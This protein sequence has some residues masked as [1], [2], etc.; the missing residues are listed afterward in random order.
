MRV[1]TYGTPFDCGTA[2]DDFTFVSFGTTTTAEEETSLPAE[3]SLSQNY[4]NPF[5]PSTTIHYELPTRSHVVL[6]VF[7]VLGQEVTT[8]VDEA[9]LAGRHQV[10]WDAD[11]FSSGVF[12][13]RLQAGEFVET[14]KLIL[15]K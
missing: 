10:R 13:Y 5:N 7:N 9:K 14:K 15:L 3:Y 11:G 8:L 6:K 4:P 1:Q 2:I 12:L